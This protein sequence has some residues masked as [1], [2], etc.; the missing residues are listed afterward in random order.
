MVVGSREYQIPSGRGEDI[1]IYLI[2]DLVGKSFEEGLMHGSGTE[3]T[4]WPAV[5]CWTKLVC[6]HR[7]L[8][9]LQLTNDICPQLRV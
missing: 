5:S 7:I 4:N 3:A 9:K 1:F 8:G 2:S 6:M